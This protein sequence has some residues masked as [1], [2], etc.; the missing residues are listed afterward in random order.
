ML[1]IKKSNVPKKLRKEFTKILKEDILESEKIDLK[2]ILTKYDN[3]GSAIENSIKTG[4]I[5]YTLPK[6]VEL[7]T[8]YKAP[9]TI[10]PVRAVL[11]WN[12][13]EP[14]NQIVPPEKIN[15]LKLN[16]FTPD[17]PRLIE[18]SKTHPDKCEAILK[19]VFNI[20]ITKQQLDFSRFGFSAIAIPKGLSKI[21]EYLIPFIDF[22]NM[23]NTNMTN[24]YILLESLGIYVE[25]V[26]TVK[27]KSN[28]IR[29]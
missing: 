7:I 19:T 3:I 10:E 14:E 23:V 24:G 25:D 28:I 4:S 6:N 27:Y 1:S 13:L 12:A 22:K 21:P 15:M 11:T 29:I 9:D 26:N 18:L 5:E 8:N 2:N 16:C 20:G 17:D